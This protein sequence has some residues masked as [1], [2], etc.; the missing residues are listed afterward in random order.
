MRDS[1]FGSFDIKV[2]VDLIV[3][4]FVNIRSRN[5]ES[6]GS[7]RPR[8]IKLNMGHVRQSSYNLSQNRDRM[9]RWFAKFDS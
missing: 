7:L 5:D 1:F 3:I 6:I 8:P 4:I 9:I 2:G